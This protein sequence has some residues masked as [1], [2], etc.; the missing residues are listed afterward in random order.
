LHEIFAADGGPLSLGRAEAASADDFARIV[1]RDEW[2]RRHLDLNQRTSP[3]SMIFRV[4][5]GDN[6]FAA[7]GACFRGGSAASSPGRMRRAEEAQRDYYVHGD[8]DV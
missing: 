7:Q 3:Q 2:P 1:S 4:I 8:R 6:G 5:V